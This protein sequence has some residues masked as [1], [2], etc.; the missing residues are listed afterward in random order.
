MWLYRTCL[1][2]ICLYI[3]GLVISYFKFNGCA[4]MWDC[5]KNCDN[6]KN[7]KCYALAKRDLFFLIGIII[8]LLTLTFS[9]NEIAFS[10]FSFAGTITSIVLSVLAIFMTIQSEAKNENVK[11]EINAAVHSLND[12]N[13]RLNQNIEESLNKLSYIDDNLDEKLAEIN[14]KLDNINK[15][16]NATN[17]PS[18]KNPKWIL[19]KNIKGDN[20]AK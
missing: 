9:D 17:V 15:K 1:F 6:N 5:D 10:H 4:N 16:V 11:A 3:V 14:S 18:K 13:N 8:C 20:N 2:L 12:I 19:T 7:N